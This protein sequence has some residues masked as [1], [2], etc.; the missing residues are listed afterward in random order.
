MQRSENGQYGGLW[1]Y[2]SPDPL[3][4]C[5]D[6]PQFFMPVRNSLKP[7]DKVCLCQINKNGR[8]LKLVDILIVDLLPKSVEIHV[9]GEIIVVP[10]SRLPVSVVT[11]EPREDYVRSDSAKSDWNVGL[12]LWEV[13]EGG[14]VVAAVVDKED[15]SAIRVGAM[16]LRFEASPRKKEAA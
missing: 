7:G 6:N 11:P 2:H 9:L 12:R 13:S 8:V 10:E 3:E 5:L 16:P 14:R 1:S 4:V 15:A